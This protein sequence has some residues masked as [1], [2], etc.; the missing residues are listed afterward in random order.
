MD[1]DE[2]MQPMP[3]DS[4]QYPADNPEQ[5]R[6]QWRSYAAVASICGFL[7]WMVYATQIPSAEYHFLTNGSGRCQDDREIKSLSECSAAAKYLNLSNHTASWDNHPFGVHYDPPFCYYE[8]GQ[9]K[10]NAG[11]NT[12]FCGYMDTCL[13]AGPPSTTIPP[14]TTAFPPTTTS[15]SGRFG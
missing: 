14:T 1:M 11:N 3:M 2:D 8:G 6:Y 5:N 13:C 9:L 7:I 4:I 15:N 10:F 12:G